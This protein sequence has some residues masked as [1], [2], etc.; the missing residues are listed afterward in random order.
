MSTIAQKLLLKCE[1]ETS[2][3]LAINWLKRTQHTPLKWM[4]SNETVAKPIKVAGI[5]FANPVGLAAGLDKNGE[6][7][8]AF[9]AMGFGFIEVGTV[10]PRP[11][12]GNPKPRLF[13]IAEKQAI[14]NRMGFNNKGIAL[15]SVRALVSLRCAI[16]DRPPRSFNHLNTKPAKYHEKVGGVL[17]IESLSAANV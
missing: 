17:Y 10:T 9:A 8:D 14:I 5:T 6:C 3:D 2:H 15:Y 16:A 1:P 12:A 4:Y 13:R 11:Q 7:I